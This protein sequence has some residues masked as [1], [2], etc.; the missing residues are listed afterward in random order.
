MDHHTLFTKLLDRKLHPAVTRLLLQWYTSQ[1]VRVKWNDSLSEPFGVT[2]GVRQG[3]VLSPILFTIYLDDLLAELEKSGVGCYWR[4]HFAGAL[5]YAD[6]IALLAPCHLLVHLE[7]CS[8]FV[9][10]M[11]QSIFWYLILTSHN[12]YA[13]PAMT[14]IQYKPVSPT[15]SHF[16]AG[17]WFSAL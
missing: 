9:S 5:C 12:S 7:Y 16:V 3:G 13:F 4:H 15:S 1:Q 14:A 11:L 10:N 17:L 6:D 8:L 2:N